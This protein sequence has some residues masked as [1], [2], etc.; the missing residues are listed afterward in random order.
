MTSNKPRDCISF[1]KKHLSGHFCLWKNLPQVRKWFRQLPKWRERMEN[2]NYTHL[3][4]MPPTLM[5]DSLS[6][7]AEY[8]FNTPLSP[9]E[10]WTNGTFHFP[11]EWYWKDG[12]LTN[13]I[14]GNRE[15][16]YLHFMHWKG[17]WW[18]PLRGSAMLRALCRSVPEPS[19]ATAG[20]G[21]DPP[22]NLRGSSASGLALPAAR[23]P[24]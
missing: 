22:R 23:S 9:I 20:A 11:K 2:I 3:D 4:E 21:P 14:D 10:P 5:P 13:D 18:P 24:P 12:K 1:C 17:G 15:F 16:I 7:H 19:R 8:S 6:I